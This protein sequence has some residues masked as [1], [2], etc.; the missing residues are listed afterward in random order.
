MIVKNKNQYQKS[1]SFSFMPDFIVENVAAIDFE[2][3][4]TYGIKN[5]FVDLDDTVV[6]KNKFDVSQSV[7][8]AI[9]SSDM[10]VYIATNRPISKDLKNLE[11]DLRAQGV[12]HPI[13]FY[14]KPFKKYFNGALDQFGLKGH[15]T[16]MIGDRYIQDIF[17]ANHSGLHTM[18]VHKLGKSNGIID[19]LISKLEKLAT[20]NYSR[21]YSR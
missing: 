15:E 3:L 20:K 9:K 11:K 1:P 17:G 14:G 8:C 5:C 7:I 6:D 2:L 16:I 18:I 13:G 10:N 19:M 4:K 12:V 21:R